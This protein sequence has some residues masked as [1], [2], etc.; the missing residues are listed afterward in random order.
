MN[1]AITEVRTLLDKLP[2]DSNY[3]DIQYHLYVIEKIR[4]SL[5]RA[6]REGII[7]QADVEQRM[8]KWLSQ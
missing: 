4:A 6:E 8:S 1:T 7:P 3:E 2:L 5:E